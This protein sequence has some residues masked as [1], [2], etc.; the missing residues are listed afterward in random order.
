MNFLIKIVGFVSLL[1]MIGDLSDGKTE[2]RLRVGKSINVFVRYGYLGISM[3]VISYN[4][5]ERW[6]FKEPTNNVFLVS[7]VHIAS[8]KFIC[9]LIVGERFLVSAWIRNN[10]QN[11]RPLFE[12]HSDTLTHTHTLEVGY[13]I[14]FVF[15]FFA[16]YSLDLLH[17]VWIV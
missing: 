17:L 8:H 15:S 10:D 7:A 5:T 14:A 11:Y 1:L 2:S 13:G 3:K 4:D 6:L 16:R 9:I 12:A